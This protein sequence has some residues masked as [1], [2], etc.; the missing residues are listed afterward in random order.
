MFTDQPVTPTR[1][2]VLV[3]FMRSTRSSK[4][5]REML[6]NLLQPRS[7][8]GDDGSRAQSSETFKAAMQLGLIKGDST[9]TVN[10]D[11]GDRRTT[12]DIVLEALD[13][14][15]LSATSVE[16]YFAPFYSFLLALNEDGMVSSSDGASWERKFNLNV[17]RGE[18]TPNPFNAVKLT[19]LRRWYEYAGL[20]WFDPGGVFQPNPYYRVRRS[21]KKMFA[22]TKKLPSSEFMSLL[23]STCPEL[24]GGDIFKETTKDMQIANQQI[25]TLG[26][27]HALVDLHV[28]GVIRLD[29]P[30]DAHGWDLSRAEPPRD[31]FLKSNKIYT[32]ELLTLR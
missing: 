30:M 26:L 24:D 7:I 18:R 21:L 20:G 5:S 31:R 11:R 17:H 13:Q 9:V 4:L 3:D 8:V 27:S 6:L 16:P 22:G 25:C 28:D 32:I 29:C 23:A 12:R 19:G 15:V 14:V 10:F 2:E 1:V